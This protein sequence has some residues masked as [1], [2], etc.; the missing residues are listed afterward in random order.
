[1]TDAFDGLDP[2]RLAVD[3][4][5]FHPNAMGHARLAQRL[6]LALRALP[7]VARIWDEELGSA[8]RRALG[9][10]RTKSRRWLRTSRFEPTGFAPGRRA[11]HDETLGIGLGRHG[12]D[13]N[14][15][16][17]SRSLALAILP[18]PACWERVRGAVD[19]AR[20]PE[21]NRAEREGHAAGYYEGLIGGT[22]STD[23]A[24]RPGASAD[25]ASRPAGSASGK[26]TW[27]HY[28][29]DDFLQF[30]LKPSLRRNLFGQPFL[31]NAFGMHDD[32]ISLEKPEGTLRIAVL[33]SSM[34]MGWGV[35]VPGDVHQQARTMA[36]YATR[37]VQQLRRR[38]D[39]R[40]STSRRGL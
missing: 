12:P 16:S 28:L 5:D 7:E 3:R 27:C 32:P 10:E 25:R 33:G 26:P 22:A 2:A 36:G 14:R 35:R 1:M 9:S 29:D 20:S 19:S 13:R 11:N 21:M 37:P 38:G 34:D 30:E 24:Q 18:W 39:S 40:C 31:T 17:R 6:D 23:R 8:G 15:A 4:D